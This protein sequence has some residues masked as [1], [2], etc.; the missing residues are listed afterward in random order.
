MNYT[1]SDHLNY[2]QL[3]I[4]DYLRMNSAERE[5]EAR[6]WSSRRMKETDNTNRKKHRTDLLERIVAESNVSEAIKRVKRN[7]G[8]GGIDGM[9]VQALTDYMIK[10]Q[11]ELKQKILR[12]KYKPKAVRRVDIPKANGQS[13]QLGIPTVVDRVVQQAI[14]QV[15]SP[16]YEDI[17]SERSYGFRPKRDAHMALK[18]CLEYISEG[19]HWV[20]DMDLEKYFDTV[21]QSKLVQVLS[22]EVKDGRVISLIHKYMRAGIMDKGMFQ[23]SRKGVPQG[24]P[25]SPLLGNIMLNECDRE[26]E[27]RGRRFVRYADDMVIF[28]KSKRA[29]ER[30][31]ESITKFLEGKLFL[32]VNKEKTRV[33]YVD[34]IKFLG[35]GFYFD[36]ERQVQLKVHASNIQKLKSKLKQLTARSNGMSISERKS[37]LNSVIRGWINYFKLAKMKSKLKELDGWLRRRIRMVTWKRWKKVSTKFKN[38]VRAGINKWRAWQW[39]NSRKGYWAVAGSPILSRAI[40]NELFQRAGYLSLVK[41]YEEVS[42]I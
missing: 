29:A 16:I 13:R 14:A 23:E 11:D 42:K 18:Q 4:W 20:V 10:H 1:K 17:F 26:L 22:K 2:S 12:G 21:N 8:A 32:K 41:Y 31:L 6:V 27:R 40:P 24:G 33:A 15:V 35:H 36:K 39:A 30:V 38:L 3:S 7:K 19:N 28:C 25:L 37:R 34:Q 9:G 5:E